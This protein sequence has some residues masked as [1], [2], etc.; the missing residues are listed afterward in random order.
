MHSI[1]GSERRQARCDLEKILCPK[2]SIPGKRKIL[3]SSSIW[4]R[5]VMDHETGKCWGTLLLR[6][7]SD[8]RHMSVAPH[9]RGPEGRNRALGTSS[10]ATGAKL[11]ASRLGQP[12]G[13]RGWRPA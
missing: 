6:M 5:P 10:G 1:D 9:A 7:A 2:N 12:S 3:L 11:S 8:A 4:D 13:F